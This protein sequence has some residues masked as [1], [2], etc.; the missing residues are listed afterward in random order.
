MRLE[1]TPA[2]RCMAGDRAIDLQSIRW[3]QNSERA[4]RF[5]TAS[6]ARGSES[7][8]SARSRA[9][10]LLNQVHKLVASERERLPVVNYEKLVSDR[11]QLRWIRGVRHFSRGRET[12]EAARIDY[13]A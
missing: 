5:E 12:A 9:H 2:R 4:N 10:H 6:D 1:E 8:C 11:Y 7:S 13:A 3:R